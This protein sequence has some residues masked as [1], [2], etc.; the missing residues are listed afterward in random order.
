MDLQGAIMSPCWSSRFSVPAGS[1]DLG[2]FAF[3]FHSVFGRRAASR[4]QLAAP[5]YLDHAYQAR[6][7]RR[8]P[9]EM[10]ERRDVDFQFACGIEDGRAGLH[11]D[12]TAVDR[13]FRHR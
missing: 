10:A 6:R 4:H 7:V 8:Q 13:E 12:L 2:G 5:A 1:V 11:L 9:V 3:D